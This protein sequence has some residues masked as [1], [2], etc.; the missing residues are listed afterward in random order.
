[1]ACRS[2]FAEEVSRLEASVLAGPGATA[3]ALRRAV[4][5]RARRLAVGEASPPIAEELT[6]YVD[7]VALHA[8][9]VLDE[10]V[11]ALKRAGYSEDEIFEITVA[12]AL[13]SA[14]E[15]LESGLRALGR[16]GSCA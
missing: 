4:A 13:G 8:Y 11:E 6:P 9:K 1:M 12:V 15:R 16:E 3:P 2:R 10:D 5:E 14:L 7:K